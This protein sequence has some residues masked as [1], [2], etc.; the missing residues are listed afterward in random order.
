[1]MSRYI[2]NLLFWCA[3]ALVLV[4]LVVVDFGRNDQIRCIYSDEASQQERSTSVEVG[5]SRAVEAGV[6]GTMGRPTDVSRVEPG[7]HRRAQTLHRVIGW[8][9]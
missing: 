8:E 7:A 5:S 2:G 9:V 3:L 6:A 4:V 1:M